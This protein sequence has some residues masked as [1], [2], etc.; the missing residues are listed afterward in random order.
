MSPNPPPRAESSNEDVRI[1]VSL[2]GSTD[3][4]AEL[5][6][7][8][9]CL[10]Q[11][12]L[13]DSRVVDRFEFTHAVLI[14]PKGSSTVGP[15]PF[16]Y[17]V[18][19]PDTKQERQRFGVLIQCQGKAAWLGAFEL[20]IV[21][22]PPDDPRPPSPS[23]ELVI[24]DLGPPVPPS[25]NGFLDIEAGVE[26]SRN[27][28]GLAIAEYLSAELGIN[29]GRASISLRLQQQDAETESSSD[30]L[31]DV[32]FR[33]DSATGSTLTTGEI[34]FAMEPMRHRLVRPRFQGALGYGKIL[35]NSD[36]RS[37]REGFSPAISAG[38]VADLTY[39][40]SATADATLRYRAKAEELSGDFR[41]GLRLRF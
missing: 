22:R 10:S 34:V 8:A 19:A 9:E 24:N 16:N 23:P 7:E 40:V 5:E 33:S 30:E 18:P 17:P 31:S 25:G 20:Q 39:R 38:F 11:V 32:G 28:S 37:D 21:P 36:R 15:S 35:G 2:Q 4:Q 29:L 6:A 27:E 41:L 3:Q 1:R 12:L 13:A 26:F 14:F